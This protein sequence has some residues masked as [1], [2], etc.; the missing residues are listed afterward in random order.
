VAR[1]CSTPLPPLHVSYRALPLTRSQ[2]M[3][4]ASIWEHSGDQGQGR[5]LV[6]NSGPSSVNHQSGMLPSDILSVQLRVKGEQI[7]SGITLLLM[8]RQQP[9]AAMHGVCTILQFLGQQYPCC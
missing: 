7:I 3:Q 5:Q 9:A 2:N 8:C 6:A 4:E 1:C